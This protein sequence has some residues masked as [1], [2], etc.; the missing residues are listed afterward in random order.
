VVKMVKQRTGR[1]KKRKG[2]CRVVKVA[3]FWVESANMSMISA[4]NR[5]SKN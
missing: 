4:L 2:W 3:L 5:C 1:G